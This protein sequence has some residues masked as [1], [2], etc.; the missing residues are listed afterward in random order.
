MKRKLSIF[1]FI[2]Y[3]YIIFHCA[4]TIYMFT[5]SLTYGLVWLAITVLEIFFLVL[6]TKY[7]RGLLMAMIVILIIQSLFS[8]TIL[9]LGSSHNVESADY[10]LVLGYGLKDNEIQ[11]TLEMR[12]ET[13]QEY[14]IKNPKTT[15]ILCGGV[16]GKNTLS[17]ADAMY[18]Y[19]RNKGISDTRMIKEDK[20]KDTIQNIRN[21]LE[22]I[23]KYGKIVVISSD[24]H[25]Y[26]ASLICKKL[27]LEVSTYASYSPL[28]LLPN[29]LLFEKFGIIKTMLLVK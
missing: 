17:E 13:A 15:L 11:E 6:G 29:A 26:R 8:L 4:Y 25:V 22:Y 12:L 2:L 14:A 10:A 24:Y 3:A 27:G 23:N 20:S 21:S 1:D 28:S 18:K 16:T 19:L 9:L 5:K 7:S